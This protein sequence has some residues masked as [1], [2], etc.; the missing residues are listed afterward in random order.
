VLLVIKKDEK[1]V[2]V[3]REEG[4][5]IHTGLKL[6]YYA[7][8]MQQIDEGTK[9][10]PIDP[11]LVQITW[12]SIGRGHHHNAS[13]P[14]NFK[15]LFEDQGIGDI[16]HLEFIQTQ[17]CHLLG[18]LVGHSI[19]GIVFPGNVHGKV[20]AAGG[21]VDPFE[22]VNSRVHILQEGMKM[23]PPLSLDGSLLEKG[24]HE[25][26][27]SSSDTAVQKQSTGNQQPWW[28]IWFLSL[29]LIIYIQTDNRLVLIR[30][31]CI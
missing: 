2:Q 29:L 16:G 30:R 4:S 18:Q 20:A 27:L 25:H 28:S 10:A 12:W 19:N 5:I 23:N 9:V 31:T 17:Q 21:Q 11:T 3:S 7:V 1:L 14:K 15:E 8:S 13:F 26:A 22:G 24:I 6:V